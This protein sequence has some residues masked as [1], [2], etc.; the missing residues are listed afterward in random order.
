MMNLCTYLISFEMFFTDQKEYLELLMDLCET[1]PSESSTA[2]GLVCSHQQ[3][4]STLGS[5][6]RANARAL[7]QGGEHILQTGLL[8][9]HRSSYTEACTTIRLLH[10]RH[11]LQYINDLTQREMTMWTPEGRRRRDEEVCMTKEGDEVNKL[12]ELRARSGFERQLWGE[13][14]ITSTPRRTQSLLSHRQLPQQPRQTATPP[15][16]PALL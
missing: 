3:S 15:P 8:V 1:Q 2:H 6:W 9:A 7:D 13:V 4:G 11:V 14:L 10:E 5:A 12:M 16:S